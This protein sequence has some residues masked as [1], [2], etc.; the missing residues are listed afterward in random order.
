MADQGSGKKKGGDVV[1][2][3]IIFLIILVVLIG[4]FIALLKFDVA[5]LGTQIIG[6]Q[7]QDL[8][9]ASLILP[10]MPVDQVNGSGDTT[11][12][13][14]LDQAVEVLKV[15]ENLLKE[16]EKE[17]ET[18]NEQIASQQTEIDRLK[19]FETDYLQFEADKQAFDQFIVDNTDSSAFSKWYASM[20]PDNAATI[21]EQVVGKEVDEASL[22]DLVDT[23]TAM[24]ANAAAA[25]L[26]EIAT[27]RME[28]AAKIIK[29]LD[30]EAQ[31]NIMAAMDSSFAARISVYLL[32]EQYGGREWGLL[33]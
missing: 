13:E 2:G 29:R 27:T 28:E 10:D 5:G 24:D 18:L 8:P 21:Y 26:S 1:K 7:I 6:P 3:I 31:A 23:Y 30:A 9:G 33:L 12:Y 11:Q 16:K 32:P 17:A 15:T 4:G 19:V 22:K 25:I 20:Y 14:T